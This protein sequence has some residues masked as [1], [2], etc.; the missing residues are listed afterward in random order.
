[1]KKETYTLLDILKEINMTPIIP[2]LI[3]ISLPFLPIPFVQ[4]TKLLIP[5]FLR[6]NNSFPLPFPLGSRGRREIE[7]QPFTLFTFLLLLSCFLFP[8]FF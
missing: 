3:I 4:S 7:I 2:T 6:L 1:L 5:F 8:M